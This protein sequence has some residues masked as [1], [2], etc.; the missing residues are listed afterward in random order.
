M[1]RACCR[2][3]CGSLREPASRSRSVPANRHLCWAEEETGQA[4]GCRIPAA[5]SVRWSE[6]RTLS[7]SVR[8]RDLPG[9]EAN[10]APMGPLKWMTLRQQYVI[11]SC[12]SS[13]AAVHGRCRMPWQRTR[14][15]SRILA[16]RGERPALRRGRP[17][18]RLRG[19]H[20]R[21]VRPPSRSRA[22]VPSRGHR[23]PGGAGVGLTLDDL[24]II[25]E[26]F[27]RDAVTPAYR[28]AR[29]ERVEE[30]G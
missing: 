13:V 2:A 20:R 3:P 8:I 24:P 14:C 18:R 12:R 7:G 22:P 30:L 10:H 29:V 23:R 15:P 9:L 16:P 6:D 28:S 1:S 19:G 5:A 21:G 11:R 17:L 26:D 4:Q 27:T 25:F